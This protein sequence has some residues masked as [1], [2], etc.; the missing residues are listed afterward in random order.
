[1]NSSQRPLGNMDTSRQGTSTWE[2]LLLCSSL[3]SLVT[4]CILWSPHKQAWMDEIF[5]WKEV[6]DSSLLHLF[7]AIQNGADGGMPVFYATAWVWA[8][9]FWEMRGDAGD[10]GRC[11]EMRDIHDR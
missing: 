7:R 9:V 6:S 11:G 10:A 2:V 8:R 4:C 5:T 3:I 1:M